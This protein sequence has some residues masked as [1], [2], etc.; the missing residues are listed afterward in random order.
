MQPV[1]PVSDNRLRSRILSDSHLAN[2]SEVP[3][4]FVT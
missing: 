1:K 2:H 3:T 4:D